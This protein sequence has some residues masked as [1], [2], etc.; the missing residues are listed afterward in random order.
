MSGKQSG[1]KPQLAIKHLHHVV[2]WSA[3]ER[4][5]EEKDTDR[6]RRMPTKET[7]TDVVKPD[8]KREDRQ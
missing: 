2:L 1:H 8:E 5:T 3:K 6:R 4:K 7:K